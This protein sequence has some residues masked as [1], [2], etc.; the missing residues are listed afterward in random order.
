MI[1]NQVV[2][3]GL[4]IPEPR[5]ASRR[6]SPAWRRDRR[7]LGAVALT[8]AAYVA[9]E[10]VA[11]WSLP[12]DIGR[13]MVATLRLAALMFAL[14]G[15]GEALERSYRE[16][17]AEARSLHAS[18]E[19]TRA[20]WEERAHEA[21][22]AL[23]AIELAVHAASRRAT[24][25]TALPS[26]LE[27]LIRAE[28]ALLRRLLD[29][30]DAVATGQEFIVA[31]TAA[32]A[33]AVE[34][35]RGTDVEVDVPP[36]LAAVGCPLATTEILRNL[37]ENARRHAPTA[38]VRIS[39]RPLRGTVVVRVE[40][41]GPGIPRELQAHVFRRGVRGSARGNGLGLYIARSLAESQGGTLEVACHGQGTAFEL[42]LPLAVGHQVLAGVA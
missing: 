9:A 20:V 15:A 25:H 41:D 39:A 42:V 10:V 2:D 24:K 36:D 23:S 27:Q 11:G 7:F 4:A 5:A 3:L 8:L 13:T 26:S 33:V 32:S 31:E 19:A 21:R 30:R 17:T 22:S 29:D 18:A 1:G 12:A 35:L 34:R 37:I 28:V 6:R 14:I 16:R 38:A 40:D